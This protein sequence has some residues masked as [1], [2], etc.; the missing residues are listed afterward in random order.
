MV[1]RLILFQMLAAS[2]VSLYEDHVVPALLSTELQLVTVHLVLA[3]EA[4]VPRFY[5]LGLKVTI[6]ARRHLHLSAYFS[7]CPTTKDDGG[8]NSISII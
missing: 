7:H 4:A 8:E 6:Q 5:P 1:Q 2:S 3:Q